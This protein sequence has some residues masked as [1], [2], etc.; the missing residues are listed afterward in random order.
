MRLGITQTARFSLDGSPAVD[1]ILQ[2]WE[3][4]SSAAGQLDAPVPSTQQ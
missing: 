4:L 1:N 3:K 2:E